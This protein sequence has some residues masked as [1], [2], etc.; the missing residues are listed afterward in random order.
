MIM[1]FIENHFY[2]LIKEIP[3]KQSCEMPNWFKYITHNVRPF[4]TI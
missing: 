4:A 2:K 3:K 1:E